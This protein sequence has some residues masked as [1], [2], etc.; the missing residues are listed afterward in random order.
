MN[1]YPGTS[2]MDLINTASVADPG[3]HPGSNFSIP[4]PESR[5]KRHHNPHPG[6]VSAKRIQV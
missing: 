3:C 6:P 4:D 5:A 2:D 1:Q